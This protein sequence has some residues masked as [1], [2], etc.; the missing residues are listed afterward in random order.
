MYD[1]F[2]DKKGSVGIRDLCNEL[3]ITTTRLGQIFK[4]YKLAYRNPETKQWKPYKTAI[5]QG[6][7]VVKD[8]ISQRGYIYAQTRITM[9]GKQFIAAIAEC[10]KQLPAAEVKTPGNVILF[11]DP[12]EIMYPNS[13]MEDC[14][15]D[16]YPD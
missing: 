6:F 12:E 9:K 11:P 4:E 15:E 8:G 1:T 13:D 16:S 5:N 2:I 14:Y 10:E 7:M 3:G